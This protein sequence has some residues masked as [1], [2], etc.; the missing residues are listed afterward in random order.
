MG[1][2]WRGVRSVEKAQPAWAWR[3]SRR[4]PASRRAGSVFAMKSASSTA[5]RAGSSTCRKCPAA[6]EDYPLA[7]A[8]GL[9]VTYRIAAVVLVAGGACVLA[10]L[11]GRRP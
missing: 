3:I 7:E 6:L 8:F 10:T 2:A 1:A 9:A 4:L 11:P 5:K